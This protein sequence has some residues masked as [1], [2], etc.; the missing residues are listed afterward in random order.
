MNESSF[1]RRKK[2]KHVNLPYFLLVH[3]HHH[4]ITHEGWMIALPVSESL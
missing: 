2:A 4:L 1:R 3:K